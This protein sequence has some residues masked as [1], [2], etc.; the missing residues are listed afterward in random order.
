ME[1]EAMQLF[2]LLVAALSRHGIQV[3]FTFSTFN[4]KSVCLKSELKF[5][6][7]DPI[8]TTIFQEEAQ[9]TMCYKH[10]HNSK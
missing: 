5:I 9:R 6:H 2:V 1:T 7:N 4:M 10:N 8:Y 3:Q